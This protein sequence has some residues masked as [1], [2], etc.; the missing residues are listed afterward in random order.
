[1]VSEPADLGRRREPILERRFEVER[2]VDRASGRVVVLGGVFEGG[3]GEDEE[4]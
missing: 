4:D 2:P 1:M 3:G